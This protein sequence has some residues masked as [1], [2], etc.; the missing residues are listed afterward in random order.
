MKPFTDLSDAIEAIKAYNGKPEDFLLPISDEMNDPTGFTM[1]I[2]GDLM[3]SR[4]WI[5]NGFEQKDG[6]RVYKYRA[7]ELP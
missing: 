6:Y 3:L 7:M 5:P 4:G 1:A 2:L